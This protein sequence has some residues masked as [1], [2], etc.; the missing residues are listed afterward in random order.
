MDTYQQEVLD[1][2]TERLKNNKKYKLNRVFNSSELVKIACKGKTHLRKTL[3]KYPSGKDRLKRF[4]SI[5]IS[6]LVTDGVLEHIS[7][8][9]YLLKGFTAQE[10]PNMYEEVEVSEAEVSEAE[11]W[12]SEELFDNT[13]ANVT[14]NTAEDLNTFEDDL[15]ILGCL[16][17]NEA[18]TEVMEVLE[19]HTSTISEISLI[20][21]QA[22]EQ[23]DSRK[24]TRVS[25]T[26]DSIS[27]QLESI[28]EV[29][30]KINRIKSHFS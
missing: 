22:L 20:A 15:G 16:V 17:N 1:N 7:H 10:A 21:T 28:A 29:R 8:R 2:L 19:R 13:T 14:E 5:A 9:S 23:W 26:L 6:S 4:A 18:L 27:T 30:S 3:G 11:E 24:D 25:I 12:L